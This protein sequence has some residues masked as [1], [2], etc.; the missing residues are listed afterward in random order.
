MMRIHL[1][2]MSVFWSGLLG[3]G[4]KMDVRDGRH[5]LWGSSIVA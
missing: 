5:R 1:P 4:I 2:S 3:R